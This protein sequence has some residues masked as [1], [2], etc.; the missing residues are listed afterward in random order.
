MKL[1]ILLSLAAVVLTACT[2]DERKPAPSQLPPAKVTTAAVQLSSLLAVEE[3]V[4]TVRPKIRARVEAKVSGRI[5]QM[6]AA[7]GQTVKKGDLLVELGVQ[8]IR[9]KADAAQAVLDQAQRDLQRL[10]ALVASNAVSKQEHE[11]AAARVKVAEASMHEAQTMLGYA[12]VRAPFDGVVARKLADVG[13]LA[14]PGKLLLEV[15]APGAL[16]FETDVP[17]ALIGQIKP[18]AKLKVRI[19][20]LPQTLEATISEISPVADAQSRTFPVKLDLPSN[21]GLRM[22]QFG[23]V[24]IPVGESKVMRV[25]DSAVIVRGQME[26][27]MVVENE[28]AQLRLVKSGKHSD[29]QMDILSGLAAGES[30]VVSENAGSL[31]DGQSVEV[32][33]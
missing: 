32:Q 20:S 5:E 7:P 30:I 4:G 16:R 6:L 22:G 23:R 2:H 25:P 9:A 27:V 10:T 29:G 12:Q 24:E 17:E 13:D 31:T 15:E 18:A 11:S 8:E 21:E 14:M 26:A 1:S 3:I 19:A 28:R 33:P